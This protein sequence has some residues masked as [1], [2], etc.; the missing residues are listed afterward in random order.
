MYQVPFA[1]LVPRRSSSTVSVRRPRL[2]W[3]PVSA[4]PWTFLVQT[5]TNRGRDTKRVVIMAKNESIAREILDLRLP[6]NHRAATILIHSNEFAEM[7][8]TSLDDLFGEVA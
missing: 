6:S 4:Y 3:R 8:S 7:A 5:F 2:H 1:F